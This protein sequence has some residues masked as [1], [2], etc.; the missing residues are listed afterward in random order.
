MKI[1]EALRLSF[2]PVFFASLCC[3]SPLVLVVFGLASVSFAT[4]LTDTLYGDYKWYF[5]L[6]GL[7][8]LG[9]TI[10][11][12]LRKKKGI[13]SLSEAKRRKNEIINIVLVTLIAGVLGYIFWLYVVV[14]IVG[15][16]YKIW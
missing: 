13:C 6:L 1:K 9:I 10:F 5:R 7:V 2:I 12:Y 15:K 3:F 14:E 4:S 16:L 11:I 8:L